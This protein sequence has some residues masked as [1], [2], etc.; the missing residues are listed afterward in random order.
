MKRN[1]KL[2]IINFQLL[3]TLLLFVTPIMSQVTIGSDAKPQPF[4]LLELISNSKGLR[5]TQIDEWTR[6]NVLKPLLVGVADANGLVIYNTDSKCLEFWNGNDWIS[7]CADTDTDT[8]VPINS[9]SI[10]S[11]EGDELD[12]Q[13]LSTTLTATV[14]PNTATD[15]HY[16]WEYF[17]AAM[18]GW[19]PMGADLPTC[20]VDVFTLGDND[21]RVTVS[22][23]CSSGSIGKVITIS[24]LDP[25]EITTG[26]SAGR[27]T[28][29]P[30]NNKYAITYDPRDG[31][32][33]FKY[34]STVG[35]FSAHEQV[36]NL[37]TSP[38]DDDFHPTD[39][40]WTPVGPSVTYNS[41]DD[42]PYCKGNNGMQ[43][44]TAANV[45]LGLGDPCRLIGLDLDK[46]QNNP[47]GSLSL[48]D[49]DNGI[50]VTPTEV[51]NEAFVGRG[52]GEH[53]TSEHWWSKNEPGNISG[54]IPG[55][56]FPAKGVGGPFRFLPAVTGRVFDDYGYT[57]G[58]AHGQ[59]GGAATDDSKTTVYYWSNESPEWG[60]AF[61]LKFETDYII[62]IEENHANGVYPIRCMNVN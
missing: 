22:N 56:E 1:F 59:G 35:I 54:G 43:P 48:Q 14:N 16:V 47:A 33:L 8:C 23:G 58:G 34:G 21:F 55:A 25:P 29:D 36:A 51:D 32:L 37:A 20:E 62:S 27:I 15:V 57:Y 6:D 44:H 3:I 45:K 41:I 53:N 46:I 13:T 61:Y 10:N 12:D 60:G 5:L 9:C 2:T 28:W 42:V 26:G 24:R 38:P 50:W 31:G 7:L 19:F 18:G 49:I 39:M 30:I 11:S 52:P 4:S 40:A 17:S